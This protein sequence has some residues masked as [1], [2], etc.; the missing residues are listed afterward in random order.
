MPSELPR[1]CSDPRF[2]L[3]VSPVD[4]QGIPAD[5]M[6]LTAAERIGSDFLSYRPRDFNDPSRALEFA[7]RAV[8]LASRAKKKRPVEDAVAYLFRTFTNLVDREIE[9]TRRFVA[10]DDDLLRAIGRRSVAE[11]EA[12]MENA[13][14]WREAL[15]TLDPTM[16]WVLWRLYW[17]F[18]V[19][20]IAAQLG[21][22]PNTL[23][24]RIRRARKHLKKVLDQT[25]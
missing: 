11:P 9:R 24:Q 23:S 14:S 5:P 4:A 17:G 15:E 8:Y 12:E 13:I 16:Q 18:S 1:R 21:I 3:W 20:E 22:S 6:F 19:N 2:V 25:P 10:L 7:E